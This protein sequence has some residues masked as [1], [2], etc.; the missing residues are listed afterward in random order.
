MKRISRI[1]LAALMT[2]VVIMPALS[3]QAQG[4]YYFQRYEGEPSAAWMMVD[5]LAFRPV[6]MATTVTGIGLFAGT[7]PITLVTGTSGDAMQ[8]FIERPA[9]WTFQ[10]R[11]GR[12]GY[13]RNYW[14]P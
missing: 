9:R 2:A 13:D 14:L 6:G 12:Q 5:T 8:A 7:L 1:V 11:L 4:Y 3:A 10:R